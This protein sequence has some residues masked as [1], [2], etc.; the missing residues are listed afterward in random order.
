MKPAALALAAL[1]DG[2][3]LL[4]VLAYLVGSV[5]FA[6]LIAR[7]HGVDLRQHG[8]GNPGASNCGRVLGRPWGILAYLLDMGKG[9]LPA[10]YAATH[11]D[12]DG[13]TL[14]LVLAGAAAVVGHVF[15]FW[16]RFRGGKGVATLT[17]VLLVADWR[18][19]LVAGLV[20]MLVVFAFKVIAIASI[21]LGV[22]LPL[23]VWLF[24]REAAM[25]D[26]FPLLVFTCIT[27]L[28]I[29]WTHRSNLSRLREGTEHAV[30]SGSDEG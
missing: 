21:L 7:F 1:P 6:L 9:A 27:A 11:F 17:G 22:A 18:A 30:G 8:S 15:S 12:A 24:D 29:I 10:W 5:P 14:Y 23:A 3:L 2:A 26:R 13:T 20:W 16:L 25:A 4:F 28:F 19:L